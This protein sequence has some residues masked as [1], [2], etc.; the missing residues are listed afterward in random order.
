M[1][2]LADLLT[3]REFVVSAM[4]KTLELGP[5]LGF[6]VALPF[7]VRRYTRQQKCTP[8]GM[9]FLLLGKLVR[10]LKDQIRRA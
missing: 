9:D 6:M 10:R 3:D 1:D 8:D 2:A 5:I 4:E 7:L